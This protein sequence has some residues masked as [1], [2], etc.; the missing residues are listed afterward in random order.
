MV[1]GQYIGGTFGILPPEISD[2]R[3]YLYIMIAEIQDY[4]DVLV[5]LYFCNQPGSPCFLRF[6]VRDSVSRGGQSAILFSC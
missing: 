4:K 6:L 5:K 1:L 3:E 2:K